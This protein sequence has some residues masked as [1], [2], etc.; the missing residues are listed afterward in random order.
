MKFYQR[1]IKAK[2]VELLLFL[3]EYR[4]RNQRISR[5][6]D[7]LQYKWCIIKKT[8]VRTLQILCITQNLKGV[9]QKTISEITCVIS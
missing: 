3:Q 2:E 4:L 9:I 8:S 6:Y 7:K 1:L 5:E